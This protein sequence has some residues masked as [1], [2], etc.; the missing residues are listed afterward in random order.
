M[1][2]FAFSLN[3]YL[4]FQFYL[5]NLF[6]MIWNKS[7][8]DKI[9]CQLGNDTESYTLILHNKSHWHQ[10]VFTRLASYSNVQY[11]GNI[12]VISFPFKKKIVSSEF[13]SGETGNRTTTHIP[14]KFL[15][16]NWNAQVYSRALFLWGSLAHE[17]AASTRHFW[18]PYKND[19]TQGILY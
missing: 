13:G 16:S 18:D 3:I 14:I 5:H 6:T 12:W 7:N 11:N 4:P 10:K 1:N 17:P 9:N 19:M 2:P 15:C 8:M